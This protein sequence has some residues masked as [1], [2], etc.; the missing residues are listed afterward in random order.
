MSVIL[1]PN[2][3][4]N[5]GDGSRSAI[6]S[7]KLGVYFRV[8]SIY[9]HP[10]GASPKTPGKA[11]RFSLTAQDRCILPPASRQSVE[12][13]DEELGPKSG[14]RGNRTTAGRKRQAAC[15]SDEVQVGLMLSKLSVRSGKKNIRTFFISPSLLLLYLKLGGQRRVALLIILHLVHHLLG[16]YRHEC[17]HP[18][19]D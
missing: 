19:T 13:Q 16:F 18:R 1:T 11:R 8:A 6:K 4:G 12:L 7:E 5:L 14:V 17:V 9:Y 2:R 10:F 3:P 15:Q